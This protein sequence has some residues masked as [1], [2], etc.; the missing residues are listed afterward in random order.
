MANVERQ[1]PGLA[2]DPL[3]SAGLPGLGASLAGL[4]IAL[5]LIAAFLAV[6]FGLPAQLPLQAASWLTFLAVV[7]TPGY[8]LG[9]LVT[10]RLDLDLSLIHI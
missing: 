6:G 10:W 3:P 7:V 2:M 5:G 8:L 9:E 4:S 1:A